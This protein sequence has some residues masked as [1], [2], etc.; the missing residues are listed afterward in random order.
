[1]QALV[2][3]GLADATSA[4][5][6]YLISGPKL[7]LRNQGL[8]PD[9][10]GVPLLIPARY[11]GIVEQHT[12][13]FPVVLIAFDHP[14]AP[15]DSNNMYPYP[16]HDEL[17]SGHDAVQWQYVEIM[18]MERLLPAPVGAA[19]AAHHL[20]AALCLFGGHAAVGALLCVLLDGRQR[21]ALL[22]NMTVR[23]LCECR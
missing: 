19:V 1:M 8:L 16:V 12:S 14:E 6:S 2:H 17:H 20:V 21:H 23:S 11:L 3:G 7:L 18:P 9:H 5:T 22:C 4:G 10:V 15:V 13:A